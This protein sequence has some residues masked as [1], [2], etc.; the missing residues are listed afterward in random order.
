MIYKTKL[1]NGAEIVTIDLLNI[2]ERTDIKDGDM[3]TVEVW[4]DDGQR[5]HTLDITKRIPTY[6][7]R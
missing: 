5:S 4:T 6:P 1:E 3:F 2:V 7:G